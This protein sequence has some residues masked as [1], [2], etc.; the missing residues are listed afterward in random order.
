MRGLEIVCPNCNKKIMIPEHMLAEILEKYEKS[1][2]QSTQAPPTV[3]EPVKNQ[4]VIDLEKELLVKNE[5][6]AEVMSK[7]ERNQ[8]NLTRVVKRSVKDEDMYRI[9]KERAMLIQEA[10]KIQE[11][12][13]S[14]KAQIAKINKNQIR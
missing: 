12:I 3:Q 4:A 11:E 7:L 5:Q 14:M 6:L 9:Q 2:K 1:K 13:A 10:K 8:A